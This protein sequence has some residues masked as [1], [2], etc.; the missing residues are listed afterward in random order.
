MYPQLAPR[1]LAQTGCMA[2]VR[3]RPFGSG[4]AGCNLTDDVT[5]PS[6]PRLGRMRVGCESAKLLSMHQP[7]VHYPRP[8]GYV[9]HARPDSRAGLPVTSFE[10]IAPGG[11]CTQPHRL[12]HRSAP[13][14]GGGVARAV[15]QYTH[16]H[17]HTHTVTQM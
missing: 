7:S 15:N 6:R 10:M 12:R 8:P 13:K 1:Y 17:T 5:D 9:T 14:A 3:A 2:R 11:G 4:T 16:T